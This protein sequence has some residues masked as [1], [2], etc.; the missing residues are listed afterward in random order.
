DQLD[1]ALH[2][3]VLAEALGACRERGIS[4]QGVTPF[5]LDQ[6]MRRTGGASLEANLAAVRGNVALAARIAVAAAV[7]R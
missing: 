2:D 5:L 4:G 7:A 6:L 3:R 1:P